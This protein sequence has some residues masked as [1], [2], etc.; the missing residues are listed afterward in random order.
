MAQP[1]RTPVTAFENFIFLSRNNHL[2]SIP[3]SLEAAS[4]GRA[5]ETRKRHELL[6]SNQR[7]SHQRTS[8]Y[9]SSYRCRQGNSK[10]NSLRHGLASHQVVIPGEDPDEFADLR[11]SLLDDYAPDGSA[12]T[13]LVEQI[14]EHE[15]RLRRARR[16]ESETWAN[17][18]AVP[19][20]AGD[21]DPNLAQ[22][23]HAQ[24]KQFDNLRRYETAIERAYQRAIDKL[25]K[26]KAERRKQAEYDSDV[27]RH[28]DWS[29]TGPAGGE[30][31][32]GFVSQTGSCAA[33]PSP[34]GFVSQTGSGGADPRPAAAAEA[35][36]STIGFVSQTA[37][38]G[39]AGSR[40]SAVSQATSGHWLRFA[41][42]R[43]M[44]SAAFRKAMRRPLA[45][46]RQAFAA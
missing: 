20:S 4:S 13:S 30:E 15:W 10:R 25:L 14:A 40:P 28:L 5:R 21:S 29:G 12:E 11:A 22:A 18:L 7:E 8:Q 46:L 42:P 19:A 32:I 27:R 1:A 6:R 9:R 2:Q 45:G 36:S 35:A 43:I 16:V 38:A 39:G 26:L 34:A 24:A 31:E 33:A 41:G 3:A 17:A 44:L 37:G 23:F